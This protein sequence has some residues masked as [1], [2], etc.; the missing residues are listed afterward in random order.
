MGFPTIL[1]RHDGH[2]VFAPRAVGLET[3][4]TVGWT[5][6]SSSVANVY[7]RRHRSSPSRPEAL[8]EER[9]LK[10]VLT[11]T[12]HQQCVQQILYTSS[13]S[14]TTGRTEWVW[15][16]WLGPCPVLMCREFILYA[17]GSA[18]WSRISGRAPGCAC[19]RW[20]LTA[21][22]VRAAVCWWH[23]TY[24]ILTRYQRRTKRVFIPGKYGT[25]GRLFPFNLIAFSLYQS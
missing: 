20:N 2:W 15:V 3:F 5:S 21:S 11:W 18:R 8:C 4:T 6:S 23:I 17:N 19:S 22:H 16:R 12:A 1:W 24:S 14:T 13:S 7:S 10:S 9:I 25:I